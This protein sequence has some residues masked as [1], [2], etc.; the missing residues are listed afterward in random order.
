MSENNFTQIQIDWK[1]F[2]NCYIRNKLRNRKFVKVRCAIKPSKL[3]ISNYGW[4]FH[5]C[6]SPSF[7]ARISQKR[8][9][10]LQLDQV[11]TLLGSAGVKAVRKTLMKLTLGLI[12]TFIYTS[13]QHMSPN[14]S[15]ARHLQKINVS[16]PKSLRDPFLPRPIIFKYQ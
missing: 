8:K 12:L 14:V 7:L 5:Q 13:Q 10:I 3:D 1:L 15:Q 11:F 9:M 16:Q 4:Q 6:F 2:V